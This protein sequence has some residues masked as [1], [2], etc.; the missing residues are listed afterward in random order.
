MKALCFL[1][2]PVVSFLTCI[3]KFK[4]TEI[5]VP[6]VHGSLTVLYPKEKR[7]ESRQRQIFFSEKRRKWGGLKVQYFN[8]YRKTRP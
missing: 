1:D 7:F 8:P 2:G 3:Y 4:N 5:N 6:I